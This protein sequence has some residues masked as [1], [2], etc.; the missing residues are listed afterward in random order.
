M[1]YVIRMMKMMMLV[2]VVVM[3]KMKTMMVVMMMMILGVIAVLVS[4]DWNNCRT[5]EQNQ[6]ILRHQKFAFPRARE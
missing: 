3:M 4:R 2:V 6:V 1:T 5:K